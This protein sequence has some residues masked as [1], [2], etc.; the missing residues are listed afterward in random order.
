[1]KSQG[2]IKLLRKVIGEEVRSAIKSELRPL[3]NEMNNHPIEAPEP[4]RP[5]RPVEKKQFTKNSLLNDLLNE[6]ANTPPTQEMI[7][8]STTNFTSAMGNAIGSPQHMPRPVMPLVT[9]DIN[10]VPVNMQ[11]EN[12]AKTVS[13]MTKDYSALMKAIDKKKNR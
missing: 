13:L 7:D 9:N 10:G 5:R 3:L 11:N 1:M 12:V 2:F 4:A 8:Y 6:T